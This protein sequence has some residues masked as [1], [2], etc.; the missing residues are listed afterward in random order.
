MEF[1]NPTQ[2]CLTWK[3]EKRSLYWHMSWE[4]VRNLFVFK[5]PPDEYFQAAVIASFVLIYWDISPA[6]EQRNSEHT[7]DLIKDCLNWK[8]MLNERIQSHRQL[9]QFY[10]YN[11]N[12]GKFKLCPK[13]S[14]KY[15]RI[16]NVDFSTNSVTVQLIINY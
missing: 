6:N 1:L 4:L 7:D 9:V 2:F 14:P 16:N 13:I 12:I 10:N 5:A 11:Q 8:N 15:L 3:R